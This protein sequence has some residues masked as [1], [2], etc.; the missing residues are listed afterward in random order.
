MPVSCAY[1]PEPRFIDLGPDYSDAVRS[2]DFPQTIL[3]FRNDRAAADVGLAGLSDS[4]WIAHFG[5]FQ[6]P[7]GSLPATILAESAPPALS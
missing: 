6:P 3:R 5:R 2:A 1:R 4:E 7:E